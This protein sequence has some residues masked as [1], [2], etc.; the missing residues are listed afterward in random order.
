MIRHARLAPIAPIPAPHLAALLA[1]LALLVTALAL[2]ASNALTERLL[3]ADA[4]ARVESWGAELLRRSPDL[5]PMLRGG[6][7]SDTGLA[8]LEAIRAGGDVLQ[9]RLIGT[10][11]RVLL[12]DGAADFSAGTIAARTA[13]RDADGQ[14][15]TLEAVL[16]QAPRRAV[17]RDAV[18]MAEGAIAMFGGGAFAILVWVALRR[19][20]ERSAV[21][22]A[23]FLRR[24]DATTGLA[25]HAEFR[26]RLDAA[27]AQ[28]RSQDWQVGV[29]VIDLRRFR[30]LNE[31]HG[32]ATGDLVLH[33]IAARL[34]GAVR[35]ED[36]VARLAGDRFA[37]VQSVLHEPAAAARL[38]DRLADAIAEPLPLADSLTL[39][40]TA[41][42]GLAIAPQDGAEAET[43]L[44]R[45]E[46]A[47]AIAR[48][49]PE[50]TIRSFEPALDAEAR[51]QREL[52][53]DLRA[54]IADGALT[55]HYQPQFRLRD[56]ALVGFEA[57]LRWH[58]PERGMVPPCDFIPL[59]ERT[60]LIIPLGAWVLRAACAEAARWPAPMRVAVNLSPAQFRHGGMVAT[61]A[62]ALAAT[63]LPGHLLELEVTESL[64]Q[65]D[66]AETERLLRAIRGLGVSIAMDD[67]G[68]G[69][70]SLAH[71]WRFPFSK[72]KID[73]AF[74]R[75][76]GH[77]PR[78]SAIVATIV[79]LGRILGMTVV[80]EGVETED[81]ARL[82]AQEGCDQVQ[83]WLYGRAVPAEEARALIAAEHQ[84]QR[85][86]VA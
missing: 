52:E 37:I 12:S 81:Q 36:T 30:D 50:A 11:G 27:L 86:Q 63:G 4:R 82:L 31:T 64:L 39:T 71:L 77:D 43:L 76:L 23:H 8:T 29:H 15:G 49:E 18:R 32:H 72:L 75:D 55:L 57:L 54:A 73:R 21:A 1:M 60:G 83:G 67:F 14:L 74:I 25:T 22:Q 85:R 26:E 79:G 61:I 35:R 9:F 19:R 38:A 28:A 34:C 78:L 10:D 41:D 46:K 69:W 7:V 59:A 2:L 53:R 65:Q 58:H 62:D 16:D 40:V 51:R 13:L 56:H 80:A 33:L 6:G 47:L 20:G 70:S 48:S 24:H 68:T 17:F 44:D 45:A 84:D 3:R 66:Q 42:I 5:A